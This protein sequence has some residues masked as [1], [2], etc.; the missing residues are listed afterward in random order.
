MHDLKHL[1]GQIILAVV[2]Q[3]C[4][5]PGW[6]NRLVYIYSKPKGGGE[7]IET[8]LQI[9]EW[10]RLNG[11]EHIID[12]AEEVSNSMKHILVRHISGLD[13]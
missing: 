10:T 1:K 12:V 5:G 2:P 8:A 3:K 4:S 9:D 11:I 13:E 7:V 6:S